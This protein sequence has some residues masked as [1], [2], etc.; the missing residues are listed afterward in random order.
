MLLWRLNL[1]LLRQLVRSE[2]IWH[3]ENDSLKQIHI[4]RFFLIDILKLDLHSPYLAKT[5]S[6]SHNMSQ[7]VTV[8]AVLPVAVLPSRSLCISTVVPLTTFFHCACHS[9]Y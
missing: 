6:L 7:F 8:Y 1:E 3:L 9:Y 2:L 5:P 4:H